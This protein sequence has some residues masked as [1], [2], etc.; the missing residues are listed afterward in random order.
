MIDITDSTYI[1]EQ[2]TAVAL[3]LF[4]GVHKGHCAVI[5][6]A[7]SYE[8]EGYKS[9]VFTFKTDSVTSKGHDGR[10]EMLLTDELKQEKFKQMGIEYLFSP[11]FPEMKNL[12]AEMF[13]KDILVERLNAGVAVC[14]DDFRFGKG[15]LGDCDTLRKLGQK[16]GIEVCVISHIICDEGEISSSNIRKA[17]R[18][19]E[20]KRANA[21]LG[22]N[23]LFML[24]VIDGNRIGRTLSFPTINQR[25]PK[26]QVLPRFGV[27]A[28]IVKFDGSTY[29]GVSNVGIKPTVHSDGLPLIETYIM[30]YSGNLYGKTV[31]VELVDFIRPECR[32]DSISELKCQIEKDVAGVR[33]VIYNSSERKDENE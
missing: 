17:V 32:F 24:P 13:V 30:D 2:K 4:D 31:S 16:Y 5:N 20:I 9:A 23:L 18:N 22:Y 7:V 28:S 10:I 11:D 29:Y 25:I 27:Y 19:G 12:T 15:A 21:M 6:A 26:G 33:N 8:A 3:G 1:P 14:G